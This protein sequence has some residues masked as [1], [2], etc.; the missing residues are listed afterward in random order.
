[1]TFS[2]VFNRKR[3][4]R[5]ITPCRKKKKKR[6]RNQAGVRI[7]SNS[8]QETLKSPHAFAVLFGTNFSTIKRC[9]V[10]YPNSRI[11]ACIE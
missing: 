3:W 7:M 2:S 8:I 4:K 9:E 6:E 11:H 1:M 10:L 5:D